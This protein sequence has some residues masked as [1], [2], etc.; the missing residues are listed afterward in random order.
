[1]LIASLPMYDLPELREHT[2]ALWAA[3]AHE[4]RTLGIAAPEHLTRP[5]LPLPEHWLDPS[6]LLSHTCGYPV[7]RVL[8][9]GQHVLGSFAVDAGDVERPQHGLDPSDSQVRHSIEPGWYRTVLVCRSTDPRSE[10]GMKSFVGAT[11][12]A[13]D[14]GSLSGY[15][16]LGVALAE[17]GVQPGR[18]VLTGAHAVSVEA[19]RDGLADLASIDA[20]TFSLL[21]MHR[22]AAVAGLK[23]IGRGP[24]VA[25]TPLFTAQH[26]AVDSLRTAVGNAVASLPAAT[27]D[28]LQLVG[29]VPHGKEPHEPVRALAD[30]AKAVWSA[31]PLIEP[32]A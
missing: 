14:E 17:A 6:I 4:A 15:V 16:S 28:A 24:Q 7:V 11:M 25:V 12:A 3:I 13:N 30:R 8:T 26:E 5:D 1:L 31:V 10:E 19:V 21:A 32:L 2:D 23:V 27:R 29:F 9:E 22:P 20:H 18:L